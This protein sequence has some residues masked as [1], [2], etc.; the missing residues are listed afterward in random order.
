MAS[1]AKRA[2]RRRGPR[3]TRPD[4]WQRGKWLFVGGGAVAAIA[5]LWVLTLS[6]SGPEVTGGE[7]PV[8]LESVP[9]NFDFPISLY[10]GEEI[11]GS[12]DLSF[13]EL[14]GDLPIVLNYWASNWAPCS[15]EMPE[16]QKVSRAFEG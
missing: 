11:I 5:L 15:A 9:S 2:A 3:S 16:F 13:G 4:I 6:N 14:L 12:R 7:R 1:K 8:I 10:Q